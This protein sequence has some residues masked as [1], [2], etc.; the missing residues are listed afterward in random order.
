MIHSPQAGVFLKSIS[1]LAERGRGNYALEI[2]EENLVFCWLI[3]NMQSEI[4]NYEK[5]K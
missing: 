2:I 3:F 5:K 4:T 1:L